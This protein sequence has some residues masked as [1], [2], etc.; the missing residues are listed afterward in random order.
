MESQ[1]SRAAAKNSWVTGW[2]PPSPWMGSMQMPQTSLE[3]FARRSATSLKRTNSTPGM[4]GMKG[5]RY[6]SLCGG[7]DGAHRAAVEAVV[8]GEEL[9]ADVA[10]LRR[11]D[12]R[13]GRG[14]A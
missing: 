7:G 2:M 12:G 6:F 8:E 13:R 9:C 14:R 10:A 4:T 11:G 1:S 5:S 3:N